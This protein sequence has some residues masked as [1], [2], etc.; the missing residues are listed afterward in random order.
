MIKISDKPIYTIQV[1]EGNITI[2]NEVFGFT[3]DSG[4]SYAEIKWNIFGTDNW[5]QYKE[6]LKSKE[7]T[8]LE[9]YYKIVD[10]E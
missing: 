6:L 1:Y 3:I 4:D 5:K 8:I 10:N 9:E 2:D 7:D